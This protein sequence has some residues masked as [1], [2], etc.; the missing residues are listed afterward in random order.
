MRLKRN[1]GP[2]SLK[3]KMIEINW[4]KLKWKILQTI[5]DKGVNIYK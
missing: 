4:D 5:W 3:I 2:I 1:G